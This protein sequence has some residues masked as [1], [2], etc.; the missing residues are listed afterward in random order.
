MKYLISLLITIVSFLG[1][2]T[3]QDIIQI[4]GVTMTSDS[5]ENVPFVKI[6]IN[7]QDKGDRSNYNGVFSLLCHKGDTLSFESKGYDTK[8]FVVPKNLKGNQYSM[9]QFMDQD[10]YYLPAVI[11]RQELPVGRDFEYAFRYWEFDED[12]FMVAR[13]NTSTDEIEYQM[14][15]V[16]LSGAEAQS[17]QMRQDFQNA[18]Y[19]GLAPNGINLLRVP[20]FIN[21][22]RKGNLK[23]KINYK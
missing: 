7:N 3:A 16:P 9:V 10:T 4:T 6:G 1:V 14:F 11:F 20:D 12:I 8:Y 17:S 15:T 21:A 22:W 2:A 19:R 5:L 23:R 13:K 18:S